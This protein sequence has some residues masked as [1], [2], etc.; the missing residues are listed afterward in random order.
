M[1]EKIASKAKRLELIRGI[2]AGFFPSLMWLICHFIWNII[3]KKNFE[4][5]N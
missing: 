3:E 2:T 4:G 1:S 5:Y